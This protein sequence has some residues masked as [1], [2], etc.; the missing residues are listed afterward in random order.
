MLGVVLVFS[1]CLSNCNVTLKITNRLKVNNDNLKF[2]RNFKNYITV[3]K[4]SGK[5]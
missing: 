2:N 1:L 4:I 5:Y 3:E